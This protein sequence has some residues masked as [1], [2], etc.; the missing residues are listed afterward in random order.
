MINFVGCD[1]DASEAG[2]SGIANVNEKTEIKG[3][4]W[5]NTITN[6]FFAICVVFCT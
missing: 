2:P 1:D 4:D 5:I 6:V 3:K